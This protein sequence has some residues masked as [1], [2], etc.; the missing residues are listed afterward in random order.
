MKLTFSHKPRRKK[1][2]SFALRWL[3]V[4]IIV[5]NSIAY[6]QARAMTQ[7]VS[8]GVRT[9]A[10]EELGLLAMALALTSG[11]RIPRPENRA[12]PADVGLPYGTHKLPY[13]DGSFLEA[14]FI[15]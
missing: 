11:V 3:L 14:W 15:E 8:G 12:T 6:M 5:V 13:A 10:P 7:Y 2:C 4:T 1:W 9:A